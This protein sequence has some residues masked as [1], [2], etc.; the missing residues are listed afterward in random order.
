MYYDE[1]T[2]FGIFVGPVGAVRCTAHWC[3]RK[4]FGPRIN[5]TTGYN[6]Q[7]YSNM[8]FSDMNQNFSGLSFRF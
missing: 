3:G 1:A 8:C 6:I 4:I 7:F 5:L 2:G